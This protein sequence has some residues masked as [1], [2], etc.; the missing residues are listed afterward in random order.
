MSILTLIIEAGE[1]SL[2]LMPG[3]YAIALESIV[4]LIPGNKKKEPLIR[5]KQEKEFF[6][7]ACLK[8]LDE[9]S[10][11]KSEAEL[12]AIAV[13]RSKIPNLL[14]QTNREKLSAP[15]ENLGIELNEYDKQ[16][17]ETRNAFLH[18]RFPDIT[19]LGP[20]RPL[21]RVNKDLLYCSLRFYNL[22]NKLIL[23]LI[24]FKGYFCNHSKLQQAYTGVKLDNEDYYIGVGL[25]D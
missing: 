10:I 14:Q 3:A 5:N 4:K 12:D 8:A 19:N 18:G 23:T 9:I 15:F 25:N 2:V 1:A 16:A 11:G 17:L 13:I 6:L 7:K 22:I 20:Q 24:G 21:S